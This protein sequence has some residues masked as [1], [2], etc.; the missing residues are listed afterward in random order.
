MGI[1]EGLKLGTVVGVEDGCK[2]DGFPLGAH[3]GRALDETDDGT[4]LGPLDGD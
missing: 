2:D 4:I 1:E 3:D